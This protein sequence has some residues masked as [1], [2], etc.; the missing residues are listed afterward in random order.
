MD[1]N[2]LFGSRLDYY[3]SLFR[4][5]LAL[6]LHK[7]QCFQ[8][9]LARIVTNTTKYSHITPVRKTLHW[10]P[11][12]HRSIFK[13]G[14]LVCKFLHSGYQIYFVPVLKPIC[15]IY[16]TCKSQADGVFLEVPHFV[17]SAYKSTKYFGL[18]FAYDVPKIWNELPDDVLSATPLHS[19]RKKLKPI[20]LHKHI[21]LNFC[22]FGISP[23][24]RPLL[25]L[26]IIVSC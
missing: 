4:S 1:T 13:I 14:L 12:E 17:T 25:G 6:D 21:H 19:F 10:L 24:H 26:M 3:N 16:K 22:F 5:L 7:L 23:W 20:S 9:S 11:I 8:N 15:C 2:A 18:S